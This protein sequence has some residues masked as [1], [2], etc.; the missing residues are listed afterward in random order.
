M[1]GVY[2]EYP[3]T[4]DGIGLTRRKEES[5]H[6]WDDVGKFKMKHNIPTKR[7]L[8]ELEIKPKYFFDVGL[9]NSKGILYCVFEVCYK[10][11][12]CDDKIRWLKEHNVIWY[13]LSAEW[14]MNQCHSP[15]TIQDGILRSG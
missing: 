7:E 15:Y 13:E 6:G 12:M 4:E 5:T 2:E 8:D 9:V 3:V 11:P 10:H 1:L 14:I